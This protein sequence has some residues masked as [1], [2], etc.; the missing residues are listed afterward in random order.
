MTSDCKYRPDTNRAVYSHEYAIKT[1]ICRNRQW[2]ESSS[3]G[4]EVR[5]KPMQKDVV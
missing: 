1:R 3:A 4:Y 2:E 5:I